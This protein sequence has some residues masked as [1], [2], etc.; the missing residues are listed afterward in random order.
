MKRIIFV[1]IVSLLINFIYSPCINADK[2]ISLNRAAIWVGGMAL[3]FLTSIVLDF[4]GEGSD[5]GDFS[6]GSK[7][8]PFAS[9][10]F[11]SGNYTNKLGSGYEYKIGSNIYYNNY[12]INGFDWEMGRIFS[13]GKTKWFG[14]IS[15][16]T[17]VY[18]DAI[19]LW[20]ANE[21][22]NNAYPF[23]YFNGLIYFG[24]SF[25]FFKNENMQ[26]YCGIG[27]E[28]EMF[29][30]RHIYCF[31]PTIDIKLGENLTLN[32]MFLRSFSSLGA[33]NW[34]EYFNEED[35]LDAFKQTIEIGGSFMFS[36]SFGVGVRYFSEE[37]GVG[38]NNLM[39]FQY[40]GF[41]IFITWA[42]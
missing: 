19:F 13:H 9:F 42:G 34:D 4:Y 26:I 7:P 30:G 5:F 1:L 25:L 17:E 21:Q 12:S 37:F 14:F 29:T 22:P 40:N 15:P 20:G 24:F 27:D 36:P 8:F 39:K 33:A 10:K 41:K 3:P 32:A 35:L 16:G 2:N 18:G 11:F 31:K 23:F 28:W 6:F 38:D